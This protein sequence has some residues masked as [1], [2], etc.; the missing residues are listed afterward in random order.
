MGYFQASKL[1]IL[2][3]LSSLTRKY[4]LWKGF[5]HD[6]STKKASALGGFAPWP[7]PRGSVPWTP[8]GG[9]APWTPEVPSP[10]LTIY[11]GAAPGFNQNECDVVLDVVFMD[12]HH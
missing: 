12:T 11:P 4:V 7:P 8:A 3:F 1:L 10:P 2:A 6:F 9:A 5:Y